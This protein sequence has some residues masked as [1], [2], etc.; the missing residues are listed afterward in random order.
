MGTLSWN[1]WK[2]LLNKPL[3]YALDIEIDFEFDLIW[4]DLILFG[5]ILYFFFFI[6]IF[7]EI[8]LMSF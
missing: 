5:T 2:I 3:E 4:F 1:E 6:K 8:A 7:G